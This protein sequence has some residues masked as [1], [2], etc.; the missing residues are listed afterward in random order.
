MIRFGALPLAFRPSLAR[1][2]LIYSDFAGRLHDHHAPGPHWY[3]TALG[4]VAE[5]R[6]EGLGGALVEHVATIADEEGT[7]CYLET[8]N[9]A[10]VPYYERF[11]FEVVAEATVPGSSLGHWSMLRPLRRS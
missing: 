8:N 4:T 3:L 6:G 10:N 11:A 1:R 5:R 7:A 2:L 9:E